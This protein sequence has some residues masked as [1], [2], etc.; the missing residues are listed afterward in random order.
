MPFELAHVPPLAGRPKI[1]LLLKTVPWAES[2][3][4]KLGKDGTY[5]VDKKFIDNRTSR[6]VWW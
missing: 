3:A 6:R 1:N 4:N 5:E 2:L